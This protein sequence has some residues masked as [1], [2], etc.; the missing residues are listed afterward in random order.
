MS[1]TFLLFASNGQERYHRTSNR[2]K[3]Y[4]QIILRH[5]PKIPDVNCTRT[6]YRL[7]PDCNCGFFYST[8]TN[9]QGIQQID[10]V[11]D[12]EYAVI[13]FGWLSNL[14]SNIAAQIL[15]V[16]KA[17]GVAGVRELD[18]YFSAVIINRLD[19]TFTLLSDL[20]GQKRLRYF[21]SEQNL[22]VSPHDK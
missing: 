19:K 14:S 16:Y 6:E 3:D 12:S 15:S 10:E 2:L 1:Q 4:A 8:L 9:S 13:A 17:H 21:C 20:A 22:F 7:L 11:I 5:M 18:G